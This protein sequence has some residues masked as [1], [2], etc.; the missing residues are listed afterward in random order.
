MGRK[1]QQEVENSGAADLVTPLLAEA[2]QVRAKIQADRQALEQRE[3][4][5]AAIEA[6][7]RDAVTPNLRSRVFARAEAEA[8]RVEREIA[9]AKLEIADAERKAEAMKLEHDQLMSAHK[10]AR[11]TMVEADKEA[12]QLSV[13]IGSLSFQIRTQQ[14][15]ARKASARLD[16]LQALDS[17]KP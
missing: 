17:A 12:R 11:S 7:A 9:D 5:L 4:Q 14:E 8:E 16:D 2:E 3:A 6:R 10:Q 13:K 15:R 1:T